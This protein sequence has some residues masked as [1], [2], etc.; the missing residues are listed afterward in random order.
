M[1]KKSVPCFCAEVKLNWKI[2]HFST[3]SNMEPPFEM[4][5]SHLLVSCLLTF[6][7]PL[8]YFV[9]MWVWTLN[10]QS[11][12]V[13]LENMTVIVWE[14]HCVHCSALRQ[15]P[16][17]NVK[18]LASCCPSPFQ[19][20]L[21]LLNSMFL[22]YCY[23]A[24]YI[25]I[26]ANFGKRWRILHF[27]EEKELHLEFLQTGGLY[28]I[29]QINGACWATAS[30]QRLTCTSQ[31]VCSFIC[32]HCLSPLW[33]LNSWHHCWLEVQPFGLSVASG[34]LPNSWQQLLL[35]EGL[36]LLCSTDED[37]GS[38]PFF[39]PSRISCVLT[40]AAISYFSLVRLLWWSPFFGW[41]TS[42]LRRLWGRIVTCRSLKSLC[43][44]LCSDKL[45]WG[46]LPLSS[47]NV[48]CTN[49]IWRIT[50]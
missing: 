31:P 22:L 34:V 28:S 11:V 5:C 2:P 10:M 27:D 16:V 19:Q 48:F 15:P 8:G 30:V 40:G 32:S 41:S 21:A 47:T 33:C 44:F 29:V 17:G 37:K 6:S 13:A 18:S 45:E 25:Y 12:L 7:K 23:S 43:I 36:H 9:H 35:W 20:D 24:I 39:W 26:L 42:Q 38:Y 3:P 14:S 49:I 4:N 50:C 1:Y 46:C